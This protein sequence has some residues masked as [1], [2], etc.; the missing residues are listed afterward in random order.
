[1][2]KYILEISKFNFSDCVNPLGQLSISSDD[3]LHAGKRSIMPPSLKI[4]TSK[5]RD[6]LL[7][8]ADGVEMVLTIDQLPTVADVLLQFL[9]LQVSSGS[10]SELDRIR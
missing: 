4:R 6:E 7:E 10:S 1:M 9:H 5:V 8:L 2:D 3:L